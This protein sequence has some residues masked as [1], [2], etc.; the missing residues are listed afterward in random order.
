MKIET[1]DLKPKT[2]GESLV[3][4]LRDTGFAVVTGH[5]IPSIAF[6]QFYRSWEKYFASEEKFKDLFAPD[7]QRGY[8]PMKSENAKGFSKKDLKEF[9]HIY[10]GMELGEIHGASSTWHLYHR[11]N[12]LGQELLQMIDQYSE[13]DGVSR[14][15]MPLEDMAKDSPQTLLRVLHYP[16]I[17]ED[18]D[19]AVR[20]AAHEDI[21][22]ITLL[23]AATYPGLQV[24][25]A[26]GEWIFADEHVP[27]DAII[28]NAGDMLQ[29]AS[30]GY[31]KST[32]HRVVNPIGE[33]AKISRYSMP[34]FIHPHSDVRLSDRYTAGEYLD[35]RLRELGL[36]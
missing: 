1:I 6:R 25:T 13:V 24:K 15:S 30:G 35:E 18:A 17:G 22:L 21:N 7:R 9:F 16:P 2:I 10:P 3:R 23:P 4:S 26:D 31:F 29:E 32:S 19:G 34:M 12:Q 36:K 27:K 33:G 20:A 11:L 14:F 28:V 5:G 8:Y